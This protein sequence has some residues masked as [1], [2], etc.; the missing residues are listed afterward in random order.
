MNDS[1]IIKVDGMS[2]TGCSNKLQDALS[3]VVGVSQASVTLEDGLARIHYDPQ[4]VSV[5]QLKETVEDVGFDVV[6]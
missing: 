6:A 2:C 4:T 3:K 5:K 1:I